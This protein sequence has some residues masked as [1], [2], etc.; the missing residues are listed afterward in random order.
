MRSRFLSP[1]L[2][3][4][5]IATAAVLSACTGPADDD[6][7]KP[8]EAS[9][10]ATPATPVA[11]PAATPG[12][13]PGTGKVLETMDAAGYTYVRVDLGGKEAWAAGPK[14]TVKTG[15]TVT[16]PAGMPMENYRSST[17]DRTF[18]VVWFVGAIRNGDPAAVEADAMA[19]AHKSVAAPAQPAAA[20]P[21]AAPVARLEGGRTVEE[22]VTKAAE[23]SG[24]E[25]AVRA[26]VVKASFGI[27]G[28]NWIHVQ[29]GTGAAGTNDLTV[30]T[31]AK[32][33]V[34]DV[35]VVRGKVVTDKDFGAGYKYAVIVEKASVEK[36]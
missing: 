10:S 24:Q 19:A 30:T 17:L 7:A 22:I 4:L 27:M 9:A 32:V 11:V 13:P 29:D 6:A 1:S 8:S 36:E 28:A 21:V 14:V 12:V 26:R 3:I 16:L 20:A 15:D 34:G 35:V 2:G 33:A 5:L 23:L 18:P 25:I 31:D